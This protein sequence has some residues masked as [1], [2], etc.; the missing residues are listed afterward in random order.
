MIEWPNFLGGWVF[1]AV[2][3]GI[4]SPHNASHFQISLCRGMLWGPCYTLRLSKKKNGPLNARRDQQFMCS[5]KEHGVVIHGVQLHDIRGLFITT[6]KICGR[7][8]HVREGPKGRAFGM[9]TP[10]ALHFVKL[11]IGCWIKC[12][13]RIQKCLGHLG[14]PCPKKMWELR[15]FFIPIVP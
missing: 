12:K 5:Y 8:L 7:V 15:T 6:T 14:V 4:L 13:T 11:T 10:W 1:I 9:L 2:F 3:W